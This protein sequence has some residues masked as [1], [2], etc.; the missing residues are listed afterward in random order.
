VTVCTL[1]F[2]AEIVTSSS[3]LDDNVPDSPGSSPISMR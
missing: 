2:A 1:P 3:L